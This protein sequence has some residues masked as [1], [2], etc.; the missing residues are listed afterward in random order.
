MNGRMTV[1]FNAIHQID[2]LLARGARVAWRLEGIGLLWEL[3]AARLP[4]HQVA[5]LRRVVADANRRCRQERRR[6]EDVVIAARRRQA[7]SVDQH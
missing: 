7:R 6:V 5:G 1:L 4:A 3:L 2:P